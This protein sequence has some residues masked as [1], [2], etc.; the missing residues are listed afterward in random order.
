M[1]RQPTPPNPNIEE[2][3]NDGSCPAPEFVEL[4]I[5]RTLNDSPRQRW[6]KGKVLIADD[7]YINVQVLRQYLERLNV[8]DSCEYFNNGEITINRA[9][10]LVED[11]IGQCYG[12]TGTLT[13]IALLLLDFQMPQKNGLDV[14]QA[15]RALYKSKRDI[16]E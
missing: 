9:V 15:V 4:R 3:G 12:Q 11:A 14:V 2:R 7:Q 10:K 16:L 1:P 8:N 6:R 5:K 13:P